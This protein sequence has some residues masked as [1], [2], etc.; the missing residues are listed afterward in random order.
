MSAH[1]I[2]LRPG[3]VSFPLAMQRS[4][5]NRAAELS[6]VAATAKDIAT[7][8]RDIAAVQAEIEWVRARGRSEAALTMYR[9]KLEEELAQAEPVSIADVVMKLRL[10]GGAERD[11]DEPE[12]DN[13]QQCI[14]LLIKLDDNSA[15]A[16]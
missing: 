7:I 13:I 5:C 15:R 9:F 6:V 8:A 16:I 2:E 11:G 1:I 4:A 10:V 3:R 12:S 14:A